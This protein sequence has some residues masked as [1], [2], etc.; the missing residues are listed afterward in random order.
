[1]E[2]SRQTDG[3]KDQDEQ[4]E[5]EDKDKQEDIGAEAGEKLRIEFA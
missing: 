5:E 2:E 3:K 4:R 1:M